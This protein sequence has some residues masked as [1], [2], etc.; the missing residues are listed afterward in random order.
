VHEVADERVREEVQA[1]AV[2]E[3]RQPDLVQRVADDDRVEVREVGRREDEGA[4]RAEPPHLLD[5]AVDDDAVGDARGV[6]EPRQQDL[7]RQRVQHGREADRHYARRQPVDARVEVPDD[8]LGEGPHDVAQQLALPA[9]AGEAQLPHD[10]APPRGRPLDLARRPLRLQA[11]PLVVPGVVDD[12]FEAALAR[13]ARDRV[14]DH[15]AHHLVEH[16]LPVRG[17]HAPAP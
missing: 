12:P 3:R 5:R 11:S 17:P 8:L 9:L 13:V 14:L 16:P 6:G 10:A 15:P 4:E 7:G 2:G 1:G